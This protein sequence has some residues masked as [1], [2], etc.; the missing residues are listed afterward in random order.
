VQR[1]AIYPLLGPALIF[2][3]IADVASRGRLDG[4]GYLVAAAA[5]AL[6]FARRRDF[7]GELR[8]HRLV[9]WLGLCESLALLRLLNAE[10][11]RLWTSVTEALALAMFGA[12]LLDLSL[13]VPDPLGGKRLRLGARVGSYTAAAVSFSMACVALGPSWHAFGELWLVPARFADAPVLFAAV[14]LWLALGLRVLRRRL[15]TSQEALSANL[16]ALVGLLPAALL[17]ALSLVPLP[18]SAA[19]ILRG[20]AA[21]SALVLYGGHLCLIDTRRR[22]AV[23]PAT[24]DG[25]AAVL[26]VSIA[27]GASALSSSSIPAEPLPRGLWV[28]GT[29]LLSMGLY[30]ALRSLVRRA[31]VPEAGRLLDA[32]SVTQPELGRAQ[33]LERLLAI[34]LR[35][36]RAAYGSSDARPILYGFD[37]AFEGHIDAAGAAHLNPRPPHPMLVARLREQPGELIVRADLELQLVRQPTVRPL[38]EALLELDVLCVVPLIV[39]AEL[40]GALLLPRGARRVPLGGEE[41]VALWEFARQLAGLLAVFSAKARAELRANLASLES[42]HAKAE[43][44]QWSELARRLQDDVNLLQSGR[45]LGAEAGTLVAYSPAQRALLEELKAR[46]A[47]PGALALVAESGVDVVSI[48]RFVHVHSGRADAPFIVLDCAALRADHADAALFGGKGPLGNEVGCL[49]VVVDGTLLLRDIAA[50]PLVVQEKLAR[51]LVSKRA[52]PAHSEH[53]YPVSAR[54]I[55]CAREDIAGL[56]SQGRFAVELADQFVHGPYRV[57]PLRECRED[58]GSLVLLAIDRACRLYGRGALG[59]E[60]EALAKLRAHDFPG[61]QLELSFVIERAV[62]QARGMR[63]TLADL[64]VALA[65]KSGEDPL[66][67]TLEEIERRALVH[68]LLRSGGNKSEAARLLG[69]PRTTLLDKVR[70]HKLDEQRGTDGPRLN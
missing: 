62:E 3:M 21:L 26:T 65:A 55:G 35:G 64:A 50:L 40:E 29:L 41:Q 34:S 25:V 49:R 47:R 14:A 70:R 60:D 9:G 17:G 36:L 22:L 18:P 48:A 69:V 51:A 68:A 42:T 30:V 12:L 52:E 7:A 33:T 10:T 61:N 44:A 59:I 56:A 5:I 39:E 23:T 13:S 16:W 54:L 11:P 58:I 46:A 43:I 1:I 4:Y 6:S 24:R 67:G 66:Q 2:Y 19:W 38:V 8:T 45:A 27:A 32:L 63:L 31:F 15:G 53:G 57:P 20:W 28:A 37:P